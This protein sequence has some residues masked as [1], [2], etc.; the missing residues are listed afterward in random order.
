MALMVFMKDLGTSL[1]FFGALLALL[2]AATG[3][4][5]YVLMGLLLFFLGALALYLL[6]PH[7]QTR[8]DIWLNPWDDAQG[9]GYQIV[10]S[11]FALAAGGI[12]GRG[13]G[14]GYLTLPSG[15]ARIPYVETDFIFSAIGEEL[16]LVGAVGIIL[17]YLTFAYRGYRIATR[18]G[19]DFRR[20]LAT[21]LTSIFALQAF[22]SFGDRAEKHKSAAAR[23]QNA[24]RDLDFFLLQFP[25]SQTADR[26]KALAG[27]EKIQGDLNSLAIGSPTLTETFYQQGRESFD[28]DHPEALGMLGRQPGTSP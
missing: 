21:G 7:V 24:R 18:A 10:Q 28:R 14:E 4:V 12:F 11:L 16:G 20:L 9:S 27:F 3:R 5:F 26:E 1:L 6:F 22:L 23:Y 25:A 19:D 17:L 8:V 2:Y 15:Q 13:L